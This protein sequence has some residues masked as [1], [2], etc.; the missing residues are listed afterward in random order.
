MWVGGG[1]WV[2]IFTIDFHQSNFAIDF[3]IQTQII[4]SNLSFAKSVDESEGWGRD[5]GIDFHH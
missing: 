1:I 5:L 4:L 2:L 3:R